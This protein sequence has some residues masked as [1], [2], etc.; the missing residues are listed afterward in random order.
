[1]HFDAFMEVFGSPFLIGVRKKAR[2]S[3]EPKSELQYGNILNVIGYGIGEEDGVCLVPGR[4]GNLFEFRYDVCTR[5]L[6]VR[7]QFSWVVLTEG[8]PLCNRIQEKI[9][10]ALLLGVNAWRRM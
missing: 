7:M 2:R 4:N 1:M 8:T 9:N 5:T 6:Y 10:V 3:G